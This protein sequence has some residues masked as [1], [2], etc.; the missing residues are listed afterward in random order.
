MLALL[1]QLLENP[2]S[3]NSEKIIKI[4]N[5]SLLNN[6]NNWKTVIDIFIKYSKINEN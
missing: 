2:N 1:I 4:I 6:S 3:R 5:N